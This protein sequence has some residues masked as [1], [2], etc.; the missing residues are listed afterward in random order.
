MIV[1]SDHGESFEHG[2]FFNHRDGLWDGVIRIPM[3]MKG[4]GLAKNHVVKEQVEL[5]DIAPTVLDLLGLAPLEQVHGISRADAARGKKSKERPGYTIT[6]PWRAPARLAISD[7]KRK[8]IT[9]RQAGQMFR[10]GK[11]PKETKPTDFRGVKMAWIGYSRRIR[12]EKER[13]QGPELPPR[14]PPTDE[15]KRLEAL[16]YVD[17]SGDPGAAP[18][19]R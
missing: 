8:I 3:L 11:D 14:S 19:P 15:R 18:A 2:Y 17:S 4:P 5:I 13:W 7:S 6:D 10:L 16:G 1:T 9:S 12:D